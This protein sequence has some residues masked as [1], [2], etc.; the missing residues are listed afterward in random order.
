MVGQKV[1]QKVEYLG[2][3]WVVA[4]VVHLVGLSGDP[5]VAQLVDL[6]VDLMVVM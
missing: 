6:S 1:A 2:P 3:H 5:L 4:M